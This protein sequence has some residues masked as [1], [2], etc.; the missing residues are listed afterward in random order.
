M[1]EFIWNSMFPKFYMEFGGG[2]RKTE[3]VSNTAGDAPSYQPSP[4]SAPA[5]AE[6]FNFYQPRIQGQNTGYAPEDIQTIK[7]VAV[8]NANY[9][10]DESVRRGAG[11]RRTPGGITTGGMN[12]MRESAVN[13]AL[14]VRSNALQD[15]A[16]QNAVLKHQD[17]W[18]AAAGMQGFLAE[19][20]QSAAQRYNMAAQMW[21]AKATA[22]A[23]QNMYATQAKGQDNS[24]M[25]SALGQ[26]G[27]SALS[28]YASSNANKNQSSNAGKV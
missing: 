2:G 26:I 20:D 22:D 8:N 3:T 18:N 25:W 23:Y 16:V 1:F 6:L 4:Y 9:A 27:G 14:A 10:V 24:A 13:S 5:S 11:A 7:S 28:A 17:Q 15:V 12:T 19:Q 21:N